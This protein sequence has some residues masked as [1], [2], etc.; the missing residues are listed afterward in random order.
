MLLYLCC[1]TQL[2]RQTHIPPLG[3]SVITE[4]MGLDYNAVDVVMNRH[5]QFRNSEDSQLFDKLLVMEQAALET[6]NKQ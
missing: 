2:R 5:T 4:Y 1:E 3:G 6:L